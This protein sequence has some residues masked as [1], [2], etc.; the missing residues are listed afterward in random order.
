MFL[1]SSVSIK[2]SVHCA[3]IKMK[4]VAVLIALKQSDAWKANSYTI[5]R[6]N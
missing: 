2:V 6:R 4:S 1:R 5:K 3:S